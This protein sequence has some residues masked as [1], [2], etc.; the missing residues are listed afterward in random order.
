[1]PLT[2]TLSLIREVDLDFCSVYSV[3][4]FT[5][6]PTL[7][8]LSIIIPAYRVGYVSSKGY[9]NGDVIC[10]LMQKRWISMAPSSFG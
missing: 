2:S 1:M 7:L 3:V 6:R 10:S 5:C 9:V 8:G 4:T